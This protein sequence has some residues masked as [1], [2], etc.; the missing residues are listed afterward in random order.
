MIFRK[1]KKSEERFLNT[2]T[3]YNHGENIV[4]KFI[5]LIKEV[6]SLKSFAINFL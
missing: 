2:F 1:L 6:V 4:D 5:K 3:A